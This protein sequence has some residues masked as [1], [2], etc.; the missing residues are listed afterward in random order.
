MALVETFGISYLL[1]LCSSINKSDHHLINILIQLDDAIN[2][3]HAINK[4]SEL[5]KLG[6]ATHIIHYND[7][8]GRFEARDDWILAVLH[9]ACI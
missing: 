3:V 7:K 8:K 9:E 4:L 2:K 6:L 5:R 1:G